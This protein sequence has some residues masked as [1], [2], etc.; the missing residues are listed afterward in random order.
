MELLRS[1]SDC[2]GLPDKELDVIIAEHSGSLRWS[3]ANQYYVLSLTVA[4]RA[5]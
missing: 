5:A 4:D 2:L 1:M 3:A